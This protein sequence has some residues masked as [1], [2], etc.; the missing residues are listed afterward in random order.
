MEFRVY[1]FCKFDVPNWLFIL[2][3]HLFLG[4]IWLGIVPRMDT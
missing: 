3:R 4:D 2:I 1:F